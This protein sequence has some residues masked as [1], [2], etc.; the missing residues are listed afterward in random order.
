MR[1]H[2]RLKVVAN[3][4]RESE[5]RKP[6]VGLVRKGCWR[7][8]SDNESACKG[9]DA[10]ELCDGLM[11]CVFVQLCPPSSGLGTVHARH[12]RLEGPYR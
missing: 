3:T 7:T 5:I 12:G 6:F 10:L 8:S 2:D 11:C 4:H 1:N 9:L